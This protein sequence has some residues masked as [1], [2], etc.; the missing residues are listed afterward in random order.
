MNS[1]RNTQL[2]FTLLEVIVAFA[3]A[4]ITLGILSQI[5]GQGARNL[6]LAGDYDHALTLANSLLTEYSTRTIDKETSYSENTGQFHWAVSIE[7]H[8][9]REAAPSLSPS[10]TLPPADRLRLMKINVNVAWRRHTT[11]RSINL[12]SLRLVSSDSDG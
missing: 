4:A 12:S 2:G 1:R 10:E 11:P 9:V 3:I 7:P 8:S 6:T 5:F